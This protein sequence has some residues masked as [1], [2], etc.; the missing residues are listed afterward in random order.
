MK[1]AGYIFRIFFPL[2]LGALSLFCLAFEIVDLFMNIW[3]YLDNNVPVPV[4]LEILYLYLPKTITFALPLAILFATCYMLCILSG[5]NE[6]VAMFASGISYIRAMLPLIIFS[7]LLSVGYFFFEDRV[8]VPCYKKYSD[9]KNSSLNI[10]QELNN[11]NVVIRSRDG[12]IIYKTELYEDSTKRLHNVLILVRNED[13]TLNC[14]IKANSANWDEDSSKWI[15]NNSTCYNFDENGDLRNVYIPSEI[16]QMLDEKP[17]TFKNNKVDVE[18]VTIKEAKVYIDYLRRTGL[19]SGEALS[20][21]YKKFSF[22]YVIFIVTLLA[23]GL[24]GRSRRNVIIISMILSTGASVLF[25][26]L[27]MVTMLLAKFG[28]VTPVAG[29][30]FPVIVFFIISMILL[31]YSKT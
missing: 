29:A 1:L 12:T 9:L 8:V 24:S 31:R 2:L 4:I 20:V 27:Q 23:I 14:I 28:F 19:P 22:P 3:K 17:D 25:Y 11:S 6:L 15:L 18:T 30:W 26:V 21:Y 7:L 13:K 16:E 5:H 10:E